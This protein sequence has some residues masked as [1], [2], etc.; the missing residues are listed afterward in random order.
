MSELV[1]LEPA[2]WNVGCEW[3]P[4][5]SWGGVLAVVVAVAA[6]LMEMVVVCPGVGF[7]S[8]TYTED[9]GSVGLLFT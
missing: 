7:L 9:L 3:N 5:V 2:A 1:S 8:P 6:A 4:H